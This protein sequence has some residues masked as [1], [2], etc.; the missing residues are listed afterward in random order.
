MLCFSQE[1]LQR[2]DYIGASSHL[3]WYL[4]LAI[5]AIW[6]IVFLATVKG[7]AGLAKVSGDSLDR[8]G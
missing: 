6:L 7:S 5:L 8:S 4:V 2:S 1:F 3:V